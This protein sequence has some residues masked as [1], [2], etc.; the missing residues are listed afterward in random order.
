M[1][2][3]LITDYSSVFFD[4]ANTK[5]KII[6]F[7]YD[8]EEYFKD[9]GTYF[10]FES[11]PFPIVKDIE[12][13]LYEMNCDKNYDD[14]IF[15]EKYCT[16]DNMITTKKICEHVFLNKKVCREET[17]GNKKEN[18]LIVAGSLAKNG[19]TTALVNLLN[20]IDREKRNY[21]LLF[22][23]EEVSSE[24]ERIN[25]IP[26]GVNYIP[27]M[28]DQKYTFFERLTY[29]KF[30]KQQNP[31]EEFP[32][33]L[34]R[35]FQREIDRY[36]W[37]ANFSHVIQ[38]DGYGKN[39]TMLLGEMQASKT[40]FVH[41]D[42]LNEMA[43]KHYQHRPTLKYAYRLYDKV[44]VVSQDIIQPTIEIS[45]KSENVVVVN[46]LEDPDGIKIRAEQD[47]VFENDT[48][49]R[50]YNPGGIEGVLRCGGKKFI[51]IGRFSPEKSH[52]RLL[53]AFDLFCEKY[54]DTQLI[55][56][57]GHGNLYNSTVK[58]VK[59]MKFYRN[60]TIIKSIRN[61][62][63]ILKRCD[64]FVLSSLYEGL[65]MTI[66]E[67][68]ILGVPVIS[69]DIPGPRSFLKQYHGYLCENSVEGLI[70]G[71]N[72]FMNG[73]VKTLTIDYAEYNQ[74]ALKEFENLFIDKN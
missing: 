40:I 64:L 74:N 3:C 39:V 72:D 41:N 14:Q 60:I 5:R 47:I 33:I 59:K 32:N 65:P 68:D 50:T 55:I 58:F 20:N 30:C 63:P 28:C 19:I 12:E 51:S 4:F 67:A 35:L 71:M 29:E 38:F 11:L 15:L 56:I 70:Q 54:P 7:A 16:F 23:R 45:E 61:P 22:K 66:K 26:Q 6:L 46:N 2:D 42:M 57:G 18:V 1:A 49:C 44:A 25:T 10:D 52:A 37:G 27:L 53:E 48:E 13:L 17:V 24:P 43:T 8:K 73:K 62:M 31:D 34:H 69:T 21:Y 36:Y 9:R